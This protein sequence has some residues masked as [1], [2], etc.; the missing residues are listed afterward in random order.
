MKNKLVNESIE[1]FLTPKSEK[2]INKDL[3]ILNQ[4]KK[5]VELIKASTRGNENVVEI[6]L[7]NGADVNA[8]SPTKETALM[9]A[10]MRGKLTCVEI[11][12]KNGADV[13]AKDIHGNT[14]LIYA[15][16]Y[17]HPNHEKIVEL[18]LKNGANKKDLVGLKDWRDTKEYKEVENI[19]KKHYGNI[20]NK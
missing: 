4:H 7:K 17:T 18:L 10:A 12:L 19:F 11:L 3:S 13:N 9:Y 14:A 5:N 20:D 15:S 6:L 2:E 16:R 1:N 8:S